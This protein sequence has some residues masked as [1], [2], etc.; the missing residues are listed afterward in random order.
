[1]TN[2]YRMLQVYLAQ[3][4]RYA[5]AVSACS[6]ETTMWTSNFGALGNYRQYSVAVLDDLLSVVILASSMPL[7]FFLFGSVIYIH[8]P[9]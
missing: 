9:R 6:S 2:N 5:S 8:W 3:H 1:M 4:I 7:Y